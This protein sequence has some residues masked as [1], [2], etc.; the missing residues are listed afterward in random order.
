M[1]L[2]NLNINLPTLRET[3]YSKKYSLTN[4]SNII[5]GE[6][7]QLIPHVV[8]VINSEMFNFRQPLKKISKEK[9]ETVN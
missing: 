2:D 4:Y 6:T 9:K 3:I 5:S 8:S 1:L 7:F